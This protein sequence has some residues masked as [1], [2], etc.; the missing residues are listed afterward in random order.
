V[1][2][3]GID[4]V[5]VMGTMHRVLFPIYKTKLKM[6]L[7]FDKRVWILGVSIVLAILSCIPGVYA[8]YLFN[9]DEQK[10][11]AIITFFGNLGLAALGFYSIVFETFKRILHRKD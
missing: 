4:G 6:R 8:A 1:L 3:V 2:T 10:Y 9:S 5:W 7:V 11:F